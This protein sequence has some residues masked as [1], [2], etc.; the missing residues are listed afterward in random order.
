MKRLK[1]VL[2]SSHY[3]K[4]MGYAETMLPKVM[5]ARGHEVH[6]IASTYNIYGN[7]PGYDASY[8]AFLG[9]AQVAPG[10]EVVDGYQVHRLPAQLISGY[11]RIRG[12][13]GL[14][15]RLA[16]DVVH[17]TEIASLQAFVLAAIKPFVG[18]RMFSATGQTMGIVKPYMKNPRG[19]FLKRAIYRLTRTL[20]SR[21]ASTM[22][23]RIYGVT[24]DGV[25]VATRFYG[26]PPEK[27]GLRSHG[28]D[29]VTF[30]PA[31]TPAEIGARRALRGRFGWTD[32]D[33]VCIYT[34]RFDKGKNPLILAQAI[35]SLAGK[36]SQR[37]CAL[38]VGD[39]VQ[40]EE[41]A[42]CRNVAIVPF[43]RHEPLSDHYR[44]A[45]IGIWPRQ[46]SLSML[47]AL[48]SGLPLIV[49]DQMGEPE[50]VN[51]SGLVYREN[52]VPD[53]ARVI[54]SLA[55]PAVRAPLGVV[56]RNK[57]LEKFSWTARGQA[58]E[59]DYLAAINSGR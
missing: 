20:P 4:G 14:V 3:S 57:A 33:L 37:V 42:A 10:T 50:R 47:D 36:G 55:D 22:V 30:R 23:E 6:V 13:A 17:S 5:A 53:M 7:E 29:T 1:I 2:V 27:A 48:A 11:I 56:A 31:T 35:D 9:P 45:D 28:T 8:G 21:L 25:E 15:A 38:F 24:P 58:Y 40:R 46:E 32:D 41:I 52:D 54:L 34:G 12:L 44:A 43:L 16:P 59:E 18:F 39:G 49:S 19:A 51:G 26:V